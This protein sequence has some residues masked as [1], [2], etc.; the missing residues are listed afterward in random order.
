MYHDVK[1]EINNYYSAV[2]T[3]TRGFGNWLSHLRMPLQHG[4]S[5]AGFLA[6]DSQDHAKS[7]RHSKTSLIVRER[8]DFAGHPR[9]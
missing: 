8:T 1:N 5:T 7:T 4:T 2:W 9:P 3:I 6:G